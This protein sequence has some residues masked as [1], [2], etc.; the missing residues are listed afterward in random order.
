MPNLHGGKGYKRGK[1]GSTEEKM[2]E[3]NEAEGE[4]LGRVIGVLGS[5]RFNVYC[6][7]N[8]TRICRLCGSMNKSDWINKGSIV[9][10]AV[11]GLSTSTTGNS[12]K[13][14]GDVT[15]V[16]DT[17][18]YKD[19]KGMPK[20]NH[21][22]FTQVEEKNIDDV[23]KRVKDDNVDIDDDDFFLQEGEEEG[24]A[25]AEKNA[26]EASEKEAKEAAWKESEKAR[27]V[28]MRSRREE[29]EVTFDDL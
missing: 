24:N 28:T 1:H 16:F 13:D 21:V 29:K 26:N 11:R 25:A 14:I 12:G 2:I 27:A 15:H 9:L 7:D 5:R 6:N 4:M 22:L 20:T 19:L 18:F 10:I 8:K 23:I 3:W 17:F